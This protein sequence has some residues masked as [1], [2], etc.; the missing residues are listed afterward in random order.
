ML[1]CKVIIQKLSEEDVGINI[2]EIPPNKQLGN[3]KLSKNLL[4]LSFFER[5]TIA[6]N[7]ICIEH[8]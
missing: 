6:T 5:V 8:K 4:N 7:I 1:Y 3:I 2:A